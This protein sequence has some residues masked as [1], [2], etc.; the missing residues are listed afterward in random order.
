MSD[1]ITPALSAEEWETLCTDRKSNDTI[2]LSDS[3][4]GIVVDDGVEGGYVVKEDRHALAALALHGQ[5]FG[6]TRADI[7]AIEDV[8]V[9]RDS[10]SCHDSGPLYD[11]AARI[12]ALLPPE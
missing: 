2:R 4:G 5:P 9:A 1:A 11:L 8:L 6:F 7:A 12:A 10:H 3:T